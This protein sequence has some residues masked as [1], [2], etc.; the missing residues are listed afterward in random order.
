MSM[1][2]DGDLDNDL[3]CRGRGER[4]RK[5]GFSGFTFRYIQQ[6]EVFGGKCECYIGF[7]V[8]AHIDLI[9]SVCP[10]SFLGLR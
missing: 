4:E 2:A 5:Y 7:S 8:C 1:P 9:E 10:I 3:T 6:K